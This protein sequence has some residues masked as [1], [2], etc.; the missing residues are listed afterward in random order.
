[1]ISFYKIFSRVCMLLILVVSTSV[2]GTSVFLADS[3]NWKFDNDTIKVETIAGKKAIKI[4]NG[5]ALLEGVLFEDGTVEFD[6][7]LP[8]GRAF[9]YLYFRGQSENDVE[10]F[11]IRT[12]K[13]NAPDAL[14]Y[15][16]VFQ[17]RSAWQ[18][19]HGDKG[20][21]AAELPTKQWIKI[22]IELIGSKATFWVG[23]NLKPAMVINQLGRDP[24]TGWLALRGFVPKNSS[25]DYSAY[26]SGL[27]ITPLNAK[28][29][30]S[31]LEPLP[32]GQ[33]TQW[34]V[35]PAFN[36]KQ[37][38]VTVI[39]GEV[40]AMN[41]SKPTMQP[42]G[43]F[44]FLRS[45]IIPKGVRHWT[46]VAQTELISKKAQMCKI[47]FGF[48]DEL[49]LSLNEKHI[50]YQDASYRYGF[51]RQDGLMHP[52]QLTAYVSLKKG[53]NLLRAVVSDKFGGWG[54]SA[55][56]QDCSGVIERK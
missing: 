21:A 4:R 5:K 31:N 1:M 36:T 2:N 23:D 39:P 22:K 28:S 12:H 55:R 42:D 34:R 8:G 41:W 20:T 26:F 56:M 9:A 19:Y 38:P 3:E 29:T 49:T 47:N 35:S 16:P 48:S 44:E 15:A 7:Y 17:R 52:D 37:G 14:Q 32:E 24:K 33:L 25:A 10:A 50:L 27:T 53:K 11:Y 51:R 43:S 45:I 30:L 13:S 18:L 40:S 6:V 46:V 54:L